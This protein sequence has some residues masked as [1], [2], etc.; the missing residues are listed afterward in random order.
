MMTRDYDKQKHYFYNIPHAYP[1]YIND[2]NGHNNA[3]KHLWRI[4]WLP[5]KLFVY[6]RRK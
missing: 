6:L 3:I 4:A 2:F 5:Q 1:T